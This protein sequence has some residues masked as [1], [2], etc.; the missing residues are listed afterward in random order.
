VRGE[1]DGGVWL[2]GL[3]LC[4]C[5]NGRRDEWVRL[6][7][8][9]WSLGSC[10]SFDVDFPCCPEQCRSFRFLCVS[11]RYFCLSLLTFAR[12]SHIVVQPWSR[13]ERF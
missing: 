4:V 1:W 8:V 2:A 11:V 7:K 6:G 5:G 13:F 9:G 12:E 10:I 3:D